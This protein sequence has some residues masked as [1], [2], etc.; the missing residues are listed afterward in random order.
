[1]RSRTP[2]SARSAIATVAISLAL[3]G[4]GCTSAGAPASPAAGPIVSAAWARAALELDLMFE[5][6]GKVVVQADVR[7]G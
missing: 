6:A 1:M 4:A 2:R 7:A 3:A 5:H